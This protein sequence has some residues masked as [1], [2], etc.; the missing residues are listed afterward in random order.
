VLPDPRLGWELLTVISTFA[1]NLTLLGVDTFAHAA[2]M[3][4]VEFLANFGVVL[5]LFVC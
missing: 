4:S 5:L 2:A 1:G 3:P